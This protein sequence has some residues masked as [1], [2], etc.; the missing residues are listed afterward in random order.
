MDVHVCCRRQ[1]YSIELLQQFAVNHGGGLDL[2]VGESRQAL[3]SVED[4]A[5]RRTSR[6][7]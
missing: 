1:F 7:K 4:G 2:G 5:E 6:V 3:S